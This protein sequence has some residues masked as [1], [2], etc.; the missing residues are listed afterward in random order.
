MLKWWV[1]LI[2]GV[3]SLSLGYVIGVAV[4]LEA[5]TRAQKLLDEVSKE[6]AEMKEIYDKCLTMERDRS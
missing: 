5:L 6:L 1:A 4:A 2:I 3:L